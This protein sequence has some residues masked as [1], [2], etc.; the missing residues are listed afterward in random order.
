MDY[1]P[2]FMK[3]TG[4]RCLLV[5]GGE[6]ALRKARLLRAA[7]AHVVVVAPGL[8]PELAAWAHAG[9]VEHIAGRFDPAQLEGVRLVVAATDVREV[10]RAV[11][12]AAQARAIPVNVVDDPELSS[13][14]TPAI[15]DRS[16][17]IVAVSTGGGVPVLARLVRTRLEQ[18]IPAAYGE[19]ARFASAWRDRV[20]A[21]FDSVDQRRAF[22]ESV[23]EG[24]VAEAV[25]S[26][27]TAQAEASMEQALAAAERPH[28]GCVY[29]VGAGPGSPDLLTFRALRLMQQADV[30]LHDADLAPAL[31]DLVRRD[32]E[33]VAVA[34]ADVEQ[35]RL[36]ALA[37]QGRR[38]LRLMAGAGRWG[39]APARLAAA[40]L[41][42]DAVPG[43]AVSM[44]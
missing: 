41:M 22:W 19:L 25:V 40:G 2:L 4:E 13:Y 5:G 10:N 23:L 43:V 38:V 33:R 20:K 11:S 42:C 29:L 39:D 6:V 30:V 16:P 1:F 32:A 27:R 17:L 3:L 36:Q 18:A 26:G 21:R 28:R 35:E 34:A 7:G 8:A 24:D 9:E 12:A 31:L 44:D 37:G 15:V 14:I